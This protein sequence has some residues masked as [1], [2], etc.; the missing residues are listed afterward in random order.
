MSPA[1][2]TFVLVDSA[3]KA[4]R[5][6]RILEA[7]GGS[8]EWHRGRAVA[9]LVAARHVSGQYGARVSNLNRVAA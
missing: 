5:A 7:V 4:H 3:R 6:A 1:T 9:F 8:A 2:L